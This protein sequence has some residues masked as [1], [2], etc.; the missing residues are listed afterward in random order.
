MNQFRVQ[1]DLSN[2]PNA[3]ETSGFS[4]SSTMNNLEMIIT[5]PGISQA[6]AIVEA[7]FGGPR[8][9][10]VKSVSPVFG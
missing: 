4:T 8:R 2:D 10:W 1:Y 9:V 7:M 5:A 6:Q 3:T